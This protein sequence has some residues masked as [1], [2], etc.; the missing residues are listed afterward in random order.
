MLRIIDA[1]TTSTDDEGMETDLRSL[2]E[3]WELLHSSVG[4]TLYLRAGRASNAG[5]YSGTRCRR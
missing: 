5:T 3:A 2:S 4:A 1:A